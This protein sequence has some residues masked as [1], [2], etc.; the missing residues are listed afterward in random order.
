LEALLYSLLYYLDS[1]DVMIVVAMKQSGVRMHQLTVAESNK[2]VNCALIHVGWA[3]IS[4][5]FFG[6][7]HVHIFSHVEAYRYEK[8]RAKQVR[9]NI[10]CLIVH[11]E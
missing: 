1:F 4:Q 2:L 3:V 9:P 5:Y 7:A 8:Q 6:L 10:S 11:L